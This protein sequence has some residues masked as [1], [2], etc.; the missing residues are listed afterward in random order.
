[1]EVLSN[2]SWTPSLLSRFESKLGYDLKPFLPLIAYGNNNINLQ[3]GSPGAFQAVLDTEDQG[4]GY[5]ND[6]RIALADGYQAYLSTL[7]NWTQSYLG[8]RHS[9]QVSYNLP[10]DMEASIPFVEVPECESLQFRNSVDGYR[11]FSGVAYLAGKNVVSVELGAVF[12]L[13]FR[14]TVPDLLFSTHRAVSGGVNRIVIH[15]QSYTGN[16]TATTWPGY[17]AFNYGV[18]DSY[19]NKQPTWDHGLGS[20]LEHI[21]RTQYIQQSG[22]GKF[23]LAIY[24]RQSATDPVVHTLYTADDLSSSGMCVS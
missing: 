17:T 5:V 13:A 21:A 23:D 10:M 2:I 8:L 11:Q 22:S 6:Y 24:N 9:A 18:S 20:A 15:G 4:S 16:Y 3:G 12:G 14:Y 19:M 1:M 7:G